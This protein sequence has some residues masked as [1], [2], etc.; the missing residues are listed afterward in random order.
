[1]KKVVSQIRDIDQI[2]KEL[3]N[4]STGVLALGLERD[5]VV[6]IATTFLYQ[7]KNVYFFFNEK[8]EVLE[9]I[10]FGAE[11][12]FTILKNESGAGNKKEGKNDFNPTYYMFSISITGEIK[13][14]DD[15]RSIANLKESYLKKYSSKANDREKNLKLVKV[16]FID[17]EEIQALEESGG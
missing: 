6:Q 8:D 12:S 13:E 7:D 4:I 5:K 14:V 10:H 2:E 1:M 3:K 11:V 15:D 9:N 16:V 17:T